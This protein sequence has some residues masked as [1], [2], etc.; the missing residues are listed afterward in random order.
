MMNSQPKDFEVAQ[1]PSDTISD[2]QFSPTA[3]YLSASSWDNQ[4]KIYE[5]QPNGNAIGKAFIQHEAP[6]LAT[7]WSADGSKVFSVGCDKAGRMLDLNT[8]QTVQVAAH[9][10][11]IKACKMINLPNMS[12]MLVTGSWDKTLKYWDLRQQQPAHVLNLPER[13]YALDVKNALMVA[14]TAERHVLIYNLNNPSVAHKTLVSTLKWQ[15]RV[16]TCFPDATGYALGSIEGRV[17]IE[18]IEDK[19][20]T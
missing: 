17:T 20:Q 8:N 3:D 15:T 10:A 2:L 18:Y 9:D 1:P 16:V 12:N 4:T 19:D 13:C 11:P 7:C 6:V 14:A 5:I